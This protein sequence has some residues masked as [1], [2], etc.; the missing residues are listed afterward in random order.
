M[1]RFVRCLLLIA[2]GVCLTASARVQPTPGGYCPHPPMRPLPEA[3]KRE[4]A[5]GKKLFVDAARGDDSAVG[6]EQAPWKSLAF[7][8][9]QLRPGDT[10][11][12]RG[13]IYYE[14]VALTA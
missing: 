12:L 7:A 8:A 13:G 4:L 6:S 10:L 1:R 9:R 5:P 14:R 3:A 2:A 11:Y